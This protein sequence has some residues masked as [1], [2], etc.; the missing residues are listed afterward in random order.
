MKAAAAD[1]VDE[2]SAAA[3]DA[4]GPAEGV[5]AVSSPEVPE[6]TAGAAVA[7]GVVAAAAETLDAP[8]ANGVP[9]TAVDEE[10][11]DVDGAGTDDVP[12][13]TT[14]ADAVALELSDVV[15]DVD[16]V[17]TVTDDKPSTTIAGVVEPADALVDVDEGSVDEVDDE[18]AEDEAVDDES[19]EDE[20][21]D[22]ESVDVEAEVV[23]AVV[24]TVVEDEDEL[25]VVED[26]DESVVEE[27]DVD[28]LFCI[29]TVHVFTSC[30]AAVPLA[31][32][33]GVSTTTHVS[34]S[35]PRGVLVV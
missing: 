4:A 14:P 9:V 2:D 16:A 33:I 24:E 8:A 13:T 35:R 31:S 1:G 26:D 17:G 22:D 25:S 20:A 21:V 19:A 30:T 15:E 10:D 18:S 7:A 34:V 23:A 6:V 27:A 5:G 28:E 3:A 32:V 12:S 11:A 29:V